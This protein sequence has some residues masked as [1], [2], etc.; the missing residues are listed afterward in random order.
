[1]KKS[2]LYLLASFM[3]LIITTLVVSNMASAAQGEPRGSNFDPDRHNAIQ[4][5]LENNDYEAWK[6]TVDS[7]PRITDYI[8]QD[9]FDKFAEMHQLM[10]NG[11]I[12]GA[13]AIRDELGLPDMGMMAKG[14]KRGFGMGSRAGGHGDCPF[15]QQEQVQQ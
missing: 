12:E 11:D 8:N 2:K 6:E 9:N 3:G 14:F 4:T 5:A 7:R 1:M 13:Q 10:L 15:A